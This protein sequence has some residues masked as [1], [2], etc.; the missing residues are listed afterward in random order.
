MAI[1]VAAVVFALAGGAVVDSGV[2]GQLLAVVANGLP[3]AVFVLGIG[4]IADADAGTPPSPMPSWPVDPDWA[5]AL[6]GRRCWGHRRNSGRL[7]ARP[8]RSGG[9]VQAATIRRPGDFGISCWR[10][11][12]VIA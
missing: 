9:V 6:V 1:G 8:L 5:T 10:L 7:T 2:F 3:V 12:A 4:T 11:G